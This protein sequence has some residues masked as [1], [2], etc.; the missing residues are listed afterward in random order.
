MLNEN[1]EILF[2]AFHLEKN[3]C[4]YFLGVSAKILCN[5]L[6]EFMFRFL[7]TS[8]PLDHGPKTRMHLP[9]RKLSC[10]QDG[11]CF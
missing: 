7:I 2:S 5:R 3:L 11:I 1:T 4:L 10:T 8:Y 9:G 6:R